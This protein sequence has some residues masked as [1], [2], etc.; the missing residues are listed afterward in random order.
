MIIKAYT[1]YELVKAQPNT[2]ED[3]FNRSEVT[4]INDGMERTLHVL[5]IRYFEEQLQEF[6]PFEGNPVFKL[7]GRDVTFKEIAALL[8]LVNCPAF[9]NRKRIYIN[10]IEEF[11]TYIDSKTVQ[12][13]QEIIEQLH[14]GIEPSLANHIA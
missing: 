14:K 11:R 9:A 13:V 4:Y 8:C 5:Y 6:T 10:T 7:E 3:Y 1:G 12:R 2:S